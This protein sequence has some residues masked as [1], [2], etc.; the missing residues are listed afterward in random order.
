MGAF[1]FGFTLTEA[2]FLGLEAG[3]DVTLGLGRGVGFVAEATGGLG[4]ELTAGRGLSIGVGVVF[5]AMTG[6]GT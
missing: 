3:R 1:F 4:I 2:T 6:G 5:D